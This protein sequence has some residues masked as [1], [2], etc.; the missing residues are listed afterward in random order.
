[1]IRGTF[2][3]RFLKRNPVNRLDVAVRSGDNVHDPAIIILE[4]AAGGEARQSADDEIGVADPAKPVIPVSACTGA[5]G[6]LVVIAATMAP[7]GS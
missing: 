6:M 3:K 5:S 1:M 2:H 4:G 7:V